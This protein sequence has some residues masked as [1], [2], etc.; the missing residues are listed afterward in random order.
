M[1]LSSACSALSICL[2]FLASGVNRT[3]ASLLDRHNRVIHALALLLAIP[4]RECRDLIVLPQ[5]HL[6]IPPRRCSQPADKTVT[7][8]F[9]SR[10]VCFAKDNRQINSRGRFTTIVY[11]LLWP[12]HSHSVLVRARIQIA[13]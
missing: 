3:Q 6:P 12:R 11:L 4:L 9:M 13:R 10:S 1:S 7:K 5:I 8:S 2:I